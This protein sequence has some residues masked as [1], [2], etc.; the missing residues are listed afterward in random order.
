ML[1]KC[2]HCNTLQRLDSCS[3][4]ITAKLELY[5]H[6][7]QQSKVLLFFSPTIEE[8]CGT[9]TAS[10]EKLLFSDSF[11]VEYSDFFPFNIAF[12]YVNRAELASGD[13]GIE[14]RLELFDGRKM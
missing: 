4:Q 6:D 3:Q 13:A 12:C 14:V 1:G 9:A 5:S 11:D 7:N 10:A 2:N 8:I